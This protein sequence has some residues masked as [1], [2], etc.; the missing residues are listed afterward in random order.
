MGIFGQLF[1]ARK[2]PMDYG[3]FGVVFSQQN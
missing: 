3:V 1:L 2:N